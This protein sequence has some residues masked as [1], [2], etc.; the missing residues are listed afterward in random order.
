MLPGS[1]LCSGGSL[2]TVSPRF[3]VSCYPKEAN[4]Q[5]SGTADPGPPQTRGLG[6]RLSV[7][8]RHPRGLWCDLCVSRACDCPSC[9]CVVSRGLPCSNSETPFSQVVDRDSE[10][11]KIIRK[12]VKNTHATTHNAY[13]LKVI[14]VRLCFSSVPFCPVGSSWSFLQPG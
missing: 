5:A 6:H 11:A 8:P 10:E 9:L 14:D 2:S 7:P 13:D 3:L 1:Q 4:P 12:Y